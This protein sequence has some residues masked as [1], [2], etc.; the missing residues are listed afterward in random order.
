MIRR[1]IPALVVA[2]GAVVALVA[3]T[4]DPVEEVTPVF[5][6]VAAPWMPAAPPPGG[7]SSTWYCPGVPAAPAAPLSRP[8]VEVTVDSEPPSSEAAP[9]PDERSDGEV[10]VFNPDEDAMSG[11]IT[12]LTETDVEPLVET[13]EIAG[14]S[15][16]RFDLN[17]LVDSPYAAAIV[18]IEG[19]GGLVEQK[20]TWPVG[21]NSV[22]ES[23][24]ACANSPS[25]NWY[26]ATGDTSDGSQDLL[27][28]SN[29]HDHAAVVD[30]L[31]ATARGARTI[32][33][34]TVPPKSVRTIDL[35][36]STV[37]DEINVGV[38]VTASRGSLVVG[39]AQL[40]DQPER[41]GYSMVLG[42]PALRSQWWFA[43]GTRADD[44]TVEY[45][46]YNPSGEDVTVNPVLIGFAPEADFVVPDPIV[47]GPGA[48]Q[49]FTLGGVP[50]IPD[51]PVTAIFGTDGGE[52]VVERTIT[53]EITGI[54]TTSV[55]PGATARPDGYV[56]DTW[57]LGIGP[58]VPTESAL[59][60]SNIEP[61]EGVLTIQAIRPDGLQTV[62][63]LGAVPLA[64]SATVR[65]DLT[66]PALFGPDGVAY[67]LVLRSTTPM[68]VERVLPREPNA[69]GRVASWLLPAG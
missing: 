16:R 13:F 24:S 8:A 53:R 37:D 58:A 62:E 2:V 67:P 32:S 54:R 3:V 69:Q 22:A 35:R 50:G 23:V 15:S 61:I 65:V 38:S 57:Y 64:A 10:A 9:A 63:S 12:I 31:L 52:V 43:A 29:P 41:N 17:E 40:Y 51:G 21:S 34:Y 45:S 59:Q 33:D 49:V 30:L 25:D 60:L 28:L 7:L 42:A 5:S 44:T 39:R 66:D 46:I 14:F 55:T 26:F 6:N 19:G 56:A 4:R 27:V 68:F 11:A 36:E 20:A 48:V 47:V 18:E 1:R